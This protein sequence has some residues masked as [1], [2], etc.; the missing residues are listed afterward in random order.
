MDSLREVGRF[1][2]LATHSRRRRKRSRG[3]SGGRACFESLRFE[4]LEARLAMSASPL[5]GAAASEA[6][7]GSAINAFGLDLYSQLQG[8]KGGN[9]FT[10]PLSIATALAMA[11][12]GAR[13]ETA[14][15][16]ADVLHF[17]QDPAAMEG[18]FAAL[19]A[20]LNA[21]G[22]AGGFSLD[23][24]DA[25]WTQ[26]GFPLLAD[27]VSAMQSNFGGGLKQVDFIHDA[28]GATKTIN[29]WV[30]QQTNGKITDL[31]APG[32]LT[33]YTRLVLT[34]AIYF[35]GQWATAFDPA[36]THNAS[37]TL[38]SGEQVS[39]PTM[40]ITGHYR[41]MEK[42]GFQVL[43]LPY[44]DGRLA[45]DVLLPTQSAG[46]QGLDISALPADLNGWLQGMSGQRVA[47]SLPKFTMTTQF[48][49]I[50]ALQALG[51]TDAFLRGADFTGI[52]SE[53]LHIGNVVHKAF[54]DVSETGTEAAA[55]TGIGMFLPTAAIAMPVDPIIFNANHPFLFLIRDTQTGSVLFTGQV[56]N[57]LQQSSDDSA[58]V[59]TPQH[60]PPPGGIQIVT[61]P[62][63]VFPPFPPISLPPVSPLPGS[64]LPVEK[65]TP[66][67]PAPVVSL[68]PNQ[69]YVTALYQRLL[70][71]A[72]EPDALAHWSSQLDQ[73]ASRESVVA[74]IQSGAE[75]RRDEVQT[76]F[77]QYLGRGADP[78]ALDFFADRLA[79]GETL[80]QVAA[81]VAGSNEYA[82]LHASDTGFV[83]A[84]F[85]AALGRAADAESSA[86]FV[87][88]LAAGVSRQQ[89]AAQVVGSLE[90]QQAVARAYLSKYLNRQPDAASV[91]Y[92]ASELH[93]G[94]RDETVI[95]QILSSEEFYAAAAQ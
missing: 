52:S 49:L 59:I 61:P 16:M 10:S 2:S 91:D 11:Y 72:V 57:P 8:E 6:A 77:Q 26:Q 7:L 30:A 13:G 14:T 45:M 50:P 19:L 85:V 81:T 65:I 28:S 54:I 63:E 35:K 40:H 20:D 83:D 70:N 44:A 94:V 93:S 95:G 32:A 1:Q 67:N 39:T 15:Q 69:Q 78:A 17:S 22:Q 23:V 43:E 31:F 46:L 9:L 12:A 55:V 36:Q 34:N 71:R 79:S 86:F 80:E 3:S 24:A 29:D 73:G 38:G 5:T 42:D 37:F 21:A 89:V 92:F 66:V 27:F 68:S 4:P 74:Q 88:E 48:D 58:P 87:G 51:M 62:I 53:Q 33:A 64:P 25:L 41:Y 82:Q 76:V 90:Y 84:L 18:A 75:F 47:V 56:E 60:Q